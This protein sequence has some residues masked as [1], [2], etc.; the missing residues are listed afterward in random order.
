MQGS[1]RTT[2]LA[3]PSI[4]IYHIQ[5][6]QGPKSQKQLRSY[7]H[8]LY[9]DDLAPVIILSLLKLFYL[10]LH[11]KAKKK[12]K[13]NSEISNLLVNIFF[14]KGQSDEIAMTIPQEKK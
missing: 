3:E 1:S 9:L 14:G 12:V 6:R 10:Y 8:Q 7:S 5:E 2:Y 4:N 11:K 13:N